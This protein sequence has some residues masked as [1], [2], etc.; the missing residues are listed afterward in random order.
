MEFLA[1]VF[2]GLG[3]IDHFLDCQTFLDQILFFNV[4]K[5]V[6]VADILC[7]FVIAPSL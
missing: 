1:P 3:A 2:A 5:E 4:I 7:E 6:I